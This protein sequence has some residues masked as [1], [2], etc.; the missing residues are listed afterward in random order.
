LK[1]KVAALALLSID[2]VWCLKFADIRLMT[3]AAF[4]DQLL[5][6]KSVRHL[7]VGDDF[8][9]GCDR[10]GDFAFLQASASDAG[11][12]VERSHTHMQDGTRISSSRIREALE[13]HDFAR[14]QSLLGR[15]FAL[16]GKVAYG[17]QLGRQLGFPTANIRLMRKPPLTGV[18]GCHVAL[19]DGT[20]AGAIA[21]I[22]T[23]PTVSGEGVWLEV[24][25]HDF[26]GQLYGQRLTVIPRFFIRPEMRFE[27]VEGLSAQIAKDNAQARQLL[28]AMDTTST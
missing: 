9:F 22:G 26:N 20:M 27:S 18:F 5:I 3:A 4:V 2:T 14:A 12:G 13:A 19:P 28:N 10:V 24:H 17:K 25:L 15:P 6:Q 16:T 7:V 21:N 1:S 23:R 8:R 11:F